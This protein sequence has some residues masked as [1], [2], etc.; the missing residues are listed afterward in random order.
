MKGKSMQVS[1]IQPNNNNTNFTSI[2][3]TKSAKITLKIHL[4]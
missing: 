4:L 1:R 2:R 3:F